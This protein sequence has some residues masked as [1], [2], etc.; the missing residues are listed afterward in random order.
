MLAPFTYAQLVGATII[1]WAVFGDVPDRW[2]LIGGAIVGG[3][4]LYLL[5]RERVRRR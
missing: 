1:G 4:G 2:T 3:S 5:W